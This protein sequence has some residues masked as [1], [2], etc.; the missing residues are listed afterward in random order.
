MV[1]YVAIYG[2]S[3]VVSVATALLVGFFVAP[4]FRLQVAPLPALAMGV[5]A[6]ACSIVLRQ[7][8]RYAAWF[9]R[10]PGAAVV[11]ISAGLGFALI[12]AGAV[13][14]AARSA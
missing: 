2:S 9:G 10:A 7:Q 13:L 6:V 14:L 5:L 1:K 11:G 3:V 4:N 8:G 12:T